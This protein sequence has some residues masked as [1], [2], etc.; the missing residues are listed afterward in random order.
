MG[1]DPAETAEACARPCCV[2][3]QLTAP[4]LSCA[5]YYWAQNSTHGAPSESHSTVGV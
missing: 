1:E 4:F 5:S 3:G 2:T